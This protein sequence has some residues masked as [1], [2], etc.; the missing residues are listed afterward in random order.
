MSATQASE[1]VVTGSQFRAVL[2]R[3]VTDLS[4]EQAQ[5]L[6]QSLGIHDTTLVNYSDFV[7][8]LGV[9]LD[10]DVP[11]SSSSTPALQRASSATSSAA[12]LSQTSPSASASHSNGASMS[13]LRPVDD[14]MLSRTPSSGVAPTPQSRPSS[15]GG[16]GMAGGMTGGMGS[17]IVG[18]GMGGGGMGGGVGASSGGGYSRPYSGT[19]LLH[20]EVIPPQSMQAYGAGVGQLGA[21]VPRRHGGHS[22]GQAVARQQ[23]PARGSSAP[24]SAVPGHVLRGRDVPNMMTRL[25]R[26][27][28]AL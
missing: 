8:A 9:L 18:G 10:G 14:S 11:S 25:S 26:S 7:G 28:N 12:A 15:E 17:G 6:Q 19:G 5:R 1:G 3:F 20:V 22:S 2:R 24:R 23:A 16:G 13:F 27:S 21:A 4:V